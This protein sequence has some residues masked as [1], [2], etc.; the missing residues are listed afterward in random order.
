[1]TEPGETAEQERSEALARATTKLG[2]YQ[3]LA[4]YVIVIGALL[5]I[6]LWTSPGYLW[7]LWPA[8]GWGIGMLAHAV[9]VFALS[10]D[11]LQRMT[12]RELRRSHTRVSR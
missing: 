1:M 12:E 9:Q 11:V 8:L 10:G 3:H 6:N 4:T 7:F 5:G 2:F